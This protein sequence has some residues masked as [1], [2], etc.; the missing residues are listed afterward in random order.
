MFGKERLTIRREEESD[1]LEGIRVDCGGQRQTGEIRVEG[2]GR[3]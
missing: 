2:A 3:G 1:I